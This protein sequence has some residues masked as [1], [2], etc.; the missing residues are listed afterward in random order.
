MPKLLSLRAYAKHRGVTL[1]AVQEAIEYGRIQKTDGKIDPTTADKEW[2][3]KT[4]PAMARGK[5]EVLD[6][7]RSRAIREAYEAQLAKLEYEEKT[8][9]LVNAEETR[10][11]WLKII[12]TAKTKLLAIP[13]KARA[14]L[15]HL[16][17]SDIATLEELVRQTLED[18]AGGAPNELN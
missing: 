1:K 12:T 10:M 15:P 14:S 3:E 17:L 18:L 9:K 11:A 16:T 7:H 13:S 4:N 6:Y 8:G 2:Q 5:T